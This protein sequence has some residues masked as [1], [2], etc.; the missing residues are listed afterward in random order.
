MN[1]SLN[2]SFD[3]MSEMLKAAKSFVPLCTI[4][5]GYL[6]DLLKHSKLEFL[7]AGDVL[8]ERLDQSQVHYFLVS[9]RLRLS[10]ASGFVESVVAG[11]SY[12]ALADEW[13]R[14]CDCIAETDATVLAVDAQQMDRLL[15]WSQIGEYA[16]SVVSAE[17]TLDE[18][19]DWINTVYRSNLFFKVPP[20]NADR[21]LDHMVSKPVTAGEVVIREG[22]I[23]DCCFF[24]KEGQAKVTRN[25]KGCDV[26]LARVGPGRCIGEDALVYETLR[27]ASVKMETDG[28]LMQLD[29]FDFKVLMEEPEVDELTEADI[30]NLQ[31]N[32]VL[33]DVRTQ[34][35]YE[36]GHLATAT[37]IP[38]NILGVKQR[39]L[40][41]N[42]P[43]V[44]YCN[45][46][47]RSRAAAY[48]LGK[49][50]YNT[51]S[52]RHGL[53]GAGMQFQTVTDYG[54]VLKDGLSVRSASPH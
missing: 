52:L 3:F 14:P 53:V 5:P 26:E 11:D 25:T 4:Q 35:E 45:T 41:Q 54:Y 20:V 13:P 6:E 16:L 51:F 46:G 19:I 18:D 34:G 50:G 39:L 15:S 9:G 49:Q 8:F 17:R 43:Y 23:G 21:I 22:Q 24:I 33:V 12:A 1:T 2:A 28:V 7:C 47:L 36:K 44:F 48:L 31:E 38:L 40:R 10:Y 30:S 29:K 42:I 27:N 32:P 37:N